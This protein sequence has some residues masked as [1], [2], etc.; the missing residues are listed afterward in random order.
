MPTFS[1]M[2]LGGGK[3]AFGIDYVYSSTSNTDRVKVGH[4]ATD[5]SHSSGVPAQLQFR[6]VYRFS[7]PCSLLPRFLDPL[8]RWQVHQ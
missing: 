4:V 7:P 5:E 2:P 8:R 3:I 6:R 1:N